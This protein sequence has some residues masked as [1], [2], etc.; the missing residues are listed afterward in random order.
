MG[1]KPRVLAVDDEQRGIELVARTLRKF[2]TV[3]LAMSGEEAWDLF[4]VAPYDVVVSDQRMPGIT[5]VELLTKIADTGLHAGRIL[6][7]GFADFAA[8]VAA[9]NNGRVHAYL[10]KPCPPDQ[11]RMITTAVFERIRVERMNEQLVDDLRGK[12]EELEEVLAS[13]RRE[14]KSMVDK[15]RVGATEGTL[16]TVAERLQ[17]VCNSMREIAVTLVQDP[18]VPERQRLADAILA[19]AD[20]AQRVCEEPPLADS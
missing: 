19:S 11:L 1:E 17:G 12:N 6:L 20:R 16:R 7:T 8:T 4:Q 3:D 13:L 14:Q 10:N 15:A 18:S 5:G 9:I 2:G